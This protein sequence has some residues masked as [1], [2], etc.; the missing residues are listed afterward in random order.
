MLLSKLI[1]YS[2]QRLTVFKHKVF[3]VGRGGAE[4][5]TQLT[6][7]FLKKKHVLNRCLG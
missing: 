7:A 1:E 4:T 5:P 2:A 6:D 3:L